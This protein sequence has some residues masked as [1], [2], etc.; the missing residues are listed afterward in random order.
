MP[1]KEDNHRAEEV[2]GD[3]LLY[4]AKPIAKYLKRSERWVY[5]QQRNLGLTHVGATLV[6]SKTKLTKLLSA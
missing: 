5:H 1:V 3:D 2:L 6:G 4:G